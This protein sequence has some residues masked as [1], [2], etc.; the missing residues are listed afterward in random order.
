MFFGLHRSIA[1]SSESLIKHGH[2]LETEKN[3]KLTSTQ[4]RKDNIFQNILM[5]PT[6]HINS[7]SHIHIP[8]PQ[9]QPQHPQ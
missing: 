8:E 1:E 2:R 9:P 5:T 3:Q 7:N 4:S 6:S